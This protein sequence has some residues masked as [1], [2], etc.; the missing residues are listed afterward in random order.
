MSLLKRGFTRP[1][2]VIYSKFN[3]TDLVVVAHLIYC[4]LG[5]MDVAQ[6]VAKKWLKYK[7]EIADEKNEQARRYYLDLLWLEK[8]GDLVDRHKHSLGELSHNICLWNQDYIFS[9]EFMMT[10]DW[11]SWREMPQGH[12]NM[13]SP[14]KNELRYIASTR[15]IRNFPEYRITAAAWGVRELDKELPTMKDK[16]HDIKCIPYRDAKFFCWSTRGT[17]LH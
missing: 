15:G 6:I 1:R 4:V 13:R 16:L 12:R 3:D 11:W 10:S 9:R 14:H 8:P 5:D 7:L 17:P 2:S